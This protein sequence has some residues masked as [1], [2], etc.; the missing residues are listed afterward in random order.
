[1]F[2]VPD[3]KNN[4]KILNDIGVYVHARNSNDINMIPL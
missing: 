1:M 2:L 4:G 3:P